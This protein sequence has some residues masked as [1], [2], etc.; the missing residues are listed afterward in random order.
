MRVSFDQTRDIGEVLLA[1]ARATGR[2][3]HRPNLALKNILKARDG[4]SVTQDILHGRARQESFVAGICLKLKPE[5][6]ASRRNVN[7]V[8]KTFDGKF[9]AQQPLNLWELLHSNYN[10][11]IK[12]DHRVHISIESLSTE[13]AIANT[14]LGQHSI[15]RLKKSV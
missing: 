6:R 1:F 5:I 14:M 7:T 4:Q 11:K 15:T 9:F 8:R 13:H 3:E 2:I 12:A 10:I